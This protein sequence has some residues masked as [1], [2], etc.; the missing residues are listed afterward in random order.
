[1][2][3]ANEEIS[4]LEA[5]SALADGELDAGTAAALV[6]ASHTDVDLLH[7]WASYH[8]I[9]DALRTHASD[10]RT[11]E[12]R[13]EAA[14]TR[15]AV[16]ALAPELRD[17]PPQTAANDALFRW[18]LVAGVAAFAAVGTMLWALVGTPGGSSGAQ[19]AQRSDAPSVGTA[20]VLPSA[21][22]STANAASTV[23]VANDGKSASDDSAQVMLRDPRLDELL[24]AHKQFGGASALQQP[25][26][27]LRNAT[28]QPTGR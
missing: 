27:F 2:K 23:L 15:P 5:L 14:P 3:H 13:V 19:L 21:P 24:A 8:A 16:L 22:N 25:A 9:G 17:A 26:G 11:H 28:F 6:Q 7:T 10:L 1:M 12:R 20:L 18:R 4:S